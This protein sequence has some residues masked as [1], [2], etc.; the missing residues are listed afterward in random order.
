MVTVI[1]STILF[2]WNFLREYN[3]TILTLKCVNMWGDGCVHL[4]GC[5]DLFTMYMSVKLPQ[6]TF[7]IP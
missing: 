5:G 7:Q 3:L 1:D 2:S 6:C 4:L